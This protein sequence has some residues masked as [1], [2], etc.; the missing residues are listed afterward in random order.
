MKGREP[1]N[2]KSNILAAFLV[3]A[4]ADEVHDPDFIG[5]GDGET[6]ALGRIAVFVCQGDDGRDRFP[7]RAGALSFRYFGNR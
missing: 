1:M 3:L 5:V 2:R 4:L 6:L 7:R